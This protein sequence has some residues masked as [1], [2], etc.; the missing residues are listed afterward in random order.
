MYRGRYRGAFLLLVV[1]AIALLA[2]V[3]VADDSEAT[4]T[5]T[6]IPSTGDWFIDQDTVASGENIRLDGYIYVPGP[7]T[8]SLDG[9]TLTF[10]NLFAGWNGI[11]VGWSATLY[12]NETSKP[13]IVRATAGHENWFFAIDGDAYM[14][15]AQ[16]EDVDYGIQNW[17]YLY[18]EDSSVETQGRYGIYSYSADL[19][20]GN[21]S[22]EVTSPGN[23][24][25]TYGLY[26]MYG[27]ASLHNIDLTVNVD[28]NYT[29][30]TSYYWGYTYTY[31]IYAYNADIGRLSPDPNKVFSITM[32]I[33]IDIHNY[34]DASNVYIYQ[35]FYTRA[36]YL[37]GSTT[38]REIVDIELSISES[39]HGAIYNATSNG[40]VYV[41]NS[42][43]Y[44]YSRVNSQGIAP[45]EISG[46]TF[47]N[48]GSQV[49]TGGMVEEP[50]VFYYN[51]AIWLDDY[52]GSRPADSVTKIHDITVSGSSFDMVILMPRYGEWE[53]YDCTFN[54]L[55]VRR[56]VQYSSGDSDYSISFNTFS[57]IT[58]METYNTDLFY[59]YSPDGEGT[60]FNNTF[61]DIDVWRLMYIYYPDDRIYFQWNTFTDIT[62]KDEV[63]EPLIYFQ[64]TQDKV[65]FSGNTIDTVH[66][67]E[68]LLYFYYARDK[69]LFKDNIV[70]D[71]Y[72]DA[73]LL[74]TYRSY[75]DVEISANDLSDNGGSMFWFEYNMQRVSFTA[76]DVTHNAVGAGYLIYTYYTY[77]ELKFNDNLFTGNSADGTLIFFKGAT[78]WG[79]YGFSFDR[80]IFND[81]V[82]S[83]ALNG[84]LVVFKSI[85]Y[86]LSVKR[87]VFNDN[88]G[89]CINFYRPYSYNSNYAYIFTVDGNDFKGNDGPATLWVDF[90]GYQIV[91]KRNTGT[92]N[93][94]PLIRHTLTAAYV[95]DYDYPQTVGQMRGPRSYV[96]DSNNYSH[97]RGGAVDIRAQWADAWYIYTN[98]GQTIGLRNNVFEYNG[99]DYSIRIVDFGQF[100]ELHNNKIYGSAYG[101]YL[102]AIDYPALFP[103]V[104]LNLVG[105]EYDGG[106]PNGM[107]AWALVDVDA[108]FTDCSFTDFQVALFARDCRIDVY[109]STIP[110]ASGRTEGRGYI[111]VWNHLEILITWADAMGVDSGQPAVGAT[112]ALLGTNG[113]YYGA[114][115]T[116][117]MGRIGPLLVMTWSSVEGKMDA[118]S[119]Y[120]GTILAGGL[121]AHHIIS[122][123]GEQVGEDSLH[124]I[125][126]DTVVPD[127]VVTSPSMDAMSN[128]VDMPVEGFL[129]ET[130][131]GIASFI[132]YMDGGEGVDVD[133]EQQWTVMFPGLEQGQHTIIFEAIDVSGNKADTTI[134]FF[135]DAIAPEL[136]IISPE[137]GDVTR[138]STL[139]VQGTYQDD[140]S[141]ISEIA[142][143]VNGEPIGTTT[144]VINYPVTLTEGVNTVTVTATD[145]AGNTE[146]VLRTITLDTYAPTLYVYTPLDALVT[147]VVLL[148]VDGLSEAG[149]PVTIDQ[150]MGDDVI[151]TITVTADDEGI[152]ETLLFLEEGL[153][154]I[155]VTA[156]DEAENVRTITR[157][158]TL[159]TTPPALFI[160]DPAPNSFVNTPS[161]VVV[162]H[163]GDDPEGVITRINGL[164]VAHS[165]V[166]SKDVPLAEGLNT[167]IV[168]ATDP[169]MNVAT[170]T[171]NVTRDTIPPELVVDNPEYILTN[172]ASLEVRGTVNADA[173]TVTVAGVAVNVEEDGSFV[174]TV[175]LATEDDPILVIA[176]DKAENTAIYTI[177]FVFDDEKPTLTL[178][179]VP[180]AVIGS[181]VMYVNG[182]VTD[183]E[184]TILF[185]TVRGEMYPVVG[186]KFNVL[187]T[188]DT[189]GNGWNNFTVSA[190]DNAGN[191][192][193]QKVSTQF[194]PEDVDDETTGPE[195]L[196]NSDLVYIGLLF[197]IAAV[198]LFMTVFMFKKRGDQS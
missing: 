35:Y 49:T 129:F 62:Q 46:L 6:P 158:V 65:T 81:N 47:S 127:V 28:M 8:L 176:T 103:R 97:N 132:G 33:D 61:S 110:E 15:G 168:T 139:V 27:S 185:V 126:D 23:I 87:N 79:P 193:I 40:Y 106:G 146:V 29:Y 147:S 137:D 160:D 182:T 197:I 17:G 69:V 11:Y 101:T 67:A 86:D 151:S 73:Y 105:E 64:E 89:N 116:D 22:I 55:V 195:G 181:L 48:L 99:N 138:I 118:W 170:R 19:H 90:S 104:T 141:E 32:D 45:T 14:N 1:A 50:R 184:A 74:R 72:F 66:M 76:N 180:K 96:V 152:F 51:Q 144:G 85:R 172:E 177:S 134:S 56:L 25:D 95:Y 18:I 123:I 159:D 3:A 194:V 24:G 98:S 119:P 148:R 163:I 20:V 189:A 2:V 161:V 9:C 173:D 191:V 164:E 26:I 10:D 115:E 192:A 53:M 198:V 39:F 174:H 70:V 142:V 122:A 59:I 117:M 120:S 124:L 60:F 112:L 171:I 5:G 154:H 41:Y 107:T 43:Q 4:V 109:W 80:N 156:E 7:W 54:N 155:I 167:I 162:G 58:M 183:N 31:G 94:G 114:L 157:T 128:M 44:I 42:Q 145:K 140:V 178:T 37:Y 68:G 38:C 57:N 143:F 150:V 91:V 30:N 78:Y 135:I 131:S 36:I 179:D 77:G 71:S 169:V 111:Y 21:S 84:G 13:A 52:S 187:L 82:A 153:Q 63:Y 75:G 188:V 93:T 92:D 12:I 121:T 166:F 113:N 133:P 175:D 196:I 125:I 136:D 100:P 149:T 34:Y 190:T 83:S 108:V 130:G 88:V 186:S 16:I 165:G 102:D